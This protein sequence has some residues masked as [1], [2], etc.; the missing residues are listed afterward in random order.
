MA[1]LDAEFTV[2]IG[3]DRLADVTQTPDR[4]EG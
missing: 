2:S 4:G 3:R 1:L